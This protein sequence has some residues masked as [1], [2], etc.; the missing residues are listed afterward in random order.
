LSVNP[1]C[2]A[3]LQYGLR[4][5]TAAWFEELLLLKW[6]PVLLLNSGYCELSY[7]QEANRAEGVAQVV[8][9]A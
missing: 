1:G 3:E 9:L 5:N 2:L 7:K 4:G 8:V 6:H